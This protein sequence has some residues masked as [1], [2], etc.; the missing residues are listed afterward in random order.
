M[1][2]N[3]KLPDLC[4]Y[5]SIGELKKS[6]PRSQANEIYKHENLYKQDE[7]KRD[8]HV[9]AYISQSKKIIECVP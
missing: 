9:T 5:A 6:D 1:Y 7:C 8:Q 3:L 2:F 4:K